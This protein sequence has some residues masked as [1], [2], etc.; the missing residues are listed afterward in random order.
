MTTFTKV[1][2]SV[3]SIYETIKEKICNDG[4][5]CD[6]V[7]MTGLACVVAWMMIEAMRPII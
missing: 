1:A 4:R 3:S 5:F 2:S 7:A 6:D